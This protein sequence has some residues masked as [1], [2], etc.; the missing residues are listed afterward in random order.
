MLLTELVKLGRQA[1][2]ITERERAV[3]AQ[4]ELCD[5]PR[6]RVANETDSDA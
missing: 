5:K 6:K 4:I 3:C 2:R 1:W